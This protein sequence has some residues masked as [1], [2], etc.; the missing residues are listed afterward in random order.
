MDKVQGDSGV[1]MTEGAIPKLVFKFAMPTMFQSVVMVIN[2]LITAVLAGRC[3]GPIA[4]GAVAVSMPI[5]FIINSIAMGT[6]QAN[7]ILLAQ[8][9]GRRDFVELKRII[10]TS[11]LC[12]MGVCVTMVTIGICFCNGLLHLIK[13]PEEIF[14]PAK[15][16]FILH[17]VGVPF[18]FT[19]F[20]FF[21]S[22]RG[23]G[24]ASRPMWLSFLSVGINIVCLPLLV[25]GIFGLPKMG[26][27][28]LG[29]SDIIANV[30]LFI[31]IFTIMK[32]E[33]SIIIPHII[34]PDFV[35][36]IAKMLLQIGFPSMIQQVLLNASI[37]FIISLVN[38]YGALVTEGYG[39]ASRI[40]GIIFAMGGAFNM[41]VS[42]IAGQN[43]GVEQYNRVGEAVKWGL[44]YALLICIIPAMV[45]IFCPEILMSIFTSD[46][47]V[48]DVG[49]T[50]LRV[51]GF[52]CLFIVVY[53]SFL[54][55]PMAAGQTYMALFVTIIATCLVRVPMAYLLNSK[56]GF[57][58]IWYSAPIAQAVAVSI[59]IWYFYSG[60]WK[61]KN[62]ISKIN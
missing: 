28:G 9:Y 8:A 21:S 1:N 2:S 60:K 29:I 55:V 50:Y 6:T 13:T 5:V 40:D 16:F 59:A 32:M 56:L 31:V 33:K 38:S 44:I 35:P 51:S 22:F 19:Q 14:V 46:Q 27:A 37:L 24:N 48:I 34:K 23:L 42:I 53:M 7:S 26:I 11:F 30:T 45:A 4:L 47:G 10:D 58:G 49:C 54:G 62:L 57:V 20:L 18:L 52:N 25:T 17:L 12:L 61:I 41:S 3:I 15:I 39:V 36:Q 43:L